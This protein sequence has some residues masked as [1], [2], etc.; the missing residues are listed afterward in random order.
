MLSH[1]SSRPDLSQKRMNTFD[2]TR[3]S[4]SYNSGDGYYLAPTRV[5]AL[6][7]KD[8]NI[9]E[10]GSAPDSVLE[11]YGSRGSAGQT[12]D[13]PA[14]KNGN[15]LVQDDDPERSRWIHRDKLAQIENRELQ[16]AGIVLPRPRPASKSGRRDRESS[17][18]QLSNGNSRSE[19]QPR[20]Q[21]VG[22][23]PRDEQAVE[24]NSNWDL[25]SPEEIA[26]ATTTYGSLGKGS[27]RLPLPKNSPVPISMDHINR[28]TPTQRKASTGWTGDDEAITYPRS[29]GRSGSG[30]ALDGSNPGPI[31]TK[32]ATSEASPKKNGAGTGRKTSTGPSARAASGQTRPKTRSGSTAKER[33]QTRS[34]DF[35]AAFKRPEGDPPWLASMYKPDPRLPPDQQLLPTHAK[36]LQQE[37]WE[38]EGKFGN[39]YDTQFRPLNEEQF[40][41]P[42]EIVPQTVETPVDK[43]TESDEWPL[44]GPKSPTLST[45]RPGTAG[46]YSTM[47]KIKDAG[48][49]PTTSPKIPVT[50]QLPPTEIIRVQ[51]PPEDVKKKGCGCCVVM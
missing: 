8:S 32:R 43:S 4:R 27:S 25:R 22:S 35:S 13:I 38:K 19:Q 40:H 6:N 21:R 5:S 26:D 31:Q 16:A 50:P 18:D 48:P 12:M 37:Q 11:L 41:Q 46:G 39:A 10:T 24:D 20:R 7:R 9:S 34:G 29:R 49:L 3:S 44:R 2:S 17:R 15:S 30:K 36:R 42:P 28:D 23:I 51:D 33:P 1:S 14:T 47:P 45:S